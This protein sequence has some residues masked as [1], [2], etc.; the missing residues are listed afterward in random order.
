MRVGDIVT[1][2]D[3]D[4]WYRNVV[5]NRLTYSHMNRKKKD[6]TIKDEEYNDH[7]LVLGYLVTKLVMSVIT[8]NIN[9]E[10]YVTLRFDML[11]PFSDGLDLLQET[12]EVNRLK[13]RMLLNKTLEELQKDYGFMYTEE[14]FKIL[15]KD[16]KNKFLDTLNSDKSKIFYL[17]DKVTHHYYEDTYTIRYLSPKRE[18]KW[19]VILENETETLDLVLTL[20]DLELVERAK[21]KDY[22]LNTTI[23]KE[24]RFIVTLD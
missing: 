19:N 23:L 13:I 9:K 3:R 4:N 11:T 6:E 7:Y 21:K 14:E 17:D 20:D 16:H 18:D 15:V 10:F 1:L 2:K 22:C 24:Y 12:T 5:F 8:Y